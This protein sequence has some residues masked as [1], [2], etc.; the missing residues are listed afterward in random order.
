MDARISDEYFHFIY[1]PQLYGFNTAYWRELN[2]ATSLTATNAIR[3]NSVAIASK[4]QYFRGSLTFN[5]NIPSA[6]AGNRRWGFV[7]P[8]LS[9]SKCAAYFETSGTFQAVVV[10]TDGSSASSTI[11]WD[12]AWTAAAVEYKIHWTKGTVLFY[13]AGIKVAEFTDRNQN[14][15]YLT[16]PV[17]IS[18]SESDN[19]DLKY[20]LVRNAEKVVKLEWEVPV[21]TAPSTENKAVEGA[22]ESITVSDVPTVTATNLGGISVNDAVA[23]TESATVEVGTESL[24]LSVTETITVAESLTP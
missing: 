7:S 8:V 18:N 6:P 23:L 17:Y 22:K 4:P 2:G 1:D 19:M 24:N 5:L 16:L 20:V 11:T 12:S 10:N 15:G 3:L 21:T 9:N 13:I 14:P